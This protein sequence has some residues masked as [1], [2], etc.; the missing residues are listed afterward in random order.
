[1][2]LRESQK[3]SRHWGVTET[4]THT[5]M[6]GFRLTSL[7]ATQWGCGNLRN[8]QVDRNKL[9]YPSS[10]HR[11]DYIL[12]GVSISEKCE[13]PLE[14]QSKIPLQ[15]SK[16]SKLFGEG[17]CPLEYAFRW[18]EIPNP[19]SIHPTETRRRAAA[20][21]PVF[22]CSSNRNHRRDPFSRGSHAKIFTLFS[23]RLLHVA[24]WIS[25]PPAHTQTDIHPKAEYFS[26]SIWSCTIQLPNKEGKA[27]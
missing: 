4:K 10:I 8:P 21:M 23:L 11:N 22:G 1:M 13:S 24:R 25:Q 17:G 5:T 27:N 18:R 14:N 26:R 2:V 6:A 15:A 12:L 9:P 16:P 7:L 3:D 20:G 19:S